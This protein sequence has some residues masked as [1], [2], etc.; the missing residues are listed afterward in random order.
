MADSKYPTPTRMGGHTA[1]P[2]VGAPRVDVAQQIDGQLYSTRGA[3]LIHTNNSG[4][5]LYNGQVG[6]FLVSVSRLIGNQPVYCV[7]P[8][9]SEE[10]KNWA[11]ANGVLDRVVVK[12]AGLGTALLAKLVREGSKSGD[13]TAEE[14]LRKIVRDR[15]DD[16][17]SLLAKQLSS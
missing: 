3:S 7:R 13:T 8:L 5:T 1:A 9:P 16:V 14:V 2:S 11:T 12:G 6:Y 15:P 4:E 10:L 17:A